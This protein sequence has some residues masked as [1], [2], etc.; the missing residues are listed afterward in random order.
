[1][2]KK[3]LLS[4]VMSL[5]LA[6]GIFLALTQTTI[7]FERTFGGKGYDAGNSVIQAKDGGYLIVG[8]TDSFGAGAGDVYLIK[9]EQ[10]GNK[11]WEKTFGG[12]EIDEGFSVVETKDGG[13]IIAGTTSSFDVEESST[14]SI[15]TGGKGNRAIE[16][17][18]DG[19]EN[20]EEEEPGFPL[21]D[22]YLIK[23]DSMGNKLWEKTF[24]GHNSDEGH[25]VIQTK[26]GGYLIVGDTT[27]FG[28]GASDV[29]LIKT[30]ENGNEGWEKTFGGK[31]SDAGNS[32]IQ[33]KD[34][35]YLIVGTTSSFGS[36]A[37]DVYL[38]K[39]DDKGNKV[40]ERTFGGK[41]D[42]VGHSVIQTKDGGYLIVGTTNSFGEGELDYD[43]YLI[44]T[45]SN[46]NKIWEKTFGGKGWEEGYSVIETM[47][48]GY[49]IAGSTESSG[50]GKADVYL[51][52]TDDKGN[53]VWGK[54][55]GGKGLDEGKA[56]I[57]TKDGGYLIVGNTTSFGSG[58]YDYDIYLIKTDS[59]GNV[60]KGGDR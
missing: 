45:D 14:Y 52:K 28:S 20:E 24:G 47:D 57:Q 6:A 16:K 33:T 54:T 11:V 51:I 53:K 30:D 43:I 34:G 56:V 1:M 13:Y 41:K 18:S 19:E 10:S 12:N 36:G 35:G 58:E 26:D 2:K 46:G 23:T 17:T 22:V 5:A 4:L 39:T 27:S 55:F 29:Y 50:A 7:T 38:I 21:S 31:G 59:K 9:T 49:L 25:S 44:K 40:W 42:D 32:V 15:K 60:Y 48:G 3:V 8:E 37:C